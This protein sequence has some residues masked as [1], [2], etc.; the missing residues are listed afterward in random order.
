MFKNTATVSLAEW[1]H[2]SWPSMT[3]MHGIWLTRS[4][5]FVRNKIYSSNQN[6]NKAARLFHEYQQQNSKISH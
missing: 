5:I 1:M 3:L 2:E 4:A 6:V